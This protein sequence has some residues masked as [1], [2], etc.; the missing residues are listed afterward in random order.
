MATDFRSD[1]GTRPTP[2][3]RSAMA[4]A[5]VGDDVFGDDPSVNA[6]EAEVAALLG[7][8]AAVYVPSGTQSNLIGVMTQCARG[9]GVRRSHPA[10]AARQRRRRDDSDRG[11]R[12]GHQAG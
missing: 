11:G 4:A 2:A 7:F 10:A 8:E 9:G 6:L 1:T 3:M 12:G 5:P